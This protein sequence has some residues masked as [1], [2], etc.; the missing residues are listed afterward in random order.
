MRW[1]VEIQGTRLERR[2]LEDLLHGMGFS[3]FEEERGLAISSRKFEQYYTSAEVHQIAK[4]LCEAFHSPV[5]PTPIDA[6]F[7]LGCVIDFS[8]DPVQRD[9]FLEVQSA[10]H[11]HK[12]F[13]DAKLIVN[14]P[15][16]LSDAQR[17]Q[18]WQEQKEAEYQ[19]KLNSQRATLEPAF[20][21]ADAREVIKLLSR[22]DPDGVILFKIF[23]LMR[24]QGTNTESFLR[25][26]GI[27][28]DEFRRFED[29]V[30]KPSVSGGWARHAV[31]TA[32]NSV[33]PMTKVEAESFIRHLSHKWLAFVRA[34][35]S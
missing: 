3:L 33:E 12:V 11:R 24:G 9:A 16:D 32:K 23:E 35:N 19:A 20:H 8:T 25:Q 1:A 30:H 7:K 28:M 15:A 18:W 26:F 29:V 5:Q 27:S 14:P 2:N 13:F 22:P 17:D 31:G 4:Q 34:Q 6:G 10:V 21:N